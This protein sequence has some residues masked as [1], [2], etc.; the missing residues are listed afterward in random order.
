M[1]RVYFCPFLEHGLWRCEAKWQGG[2]REDGYCDKTDGP[3]VSA[4]NTC[5]WMRG[6][7][8]ILVSQGMAG[9]GIKGGCLNMERLCC[10][11]AIQDERP[12]AKWMRRV[13]G[14]ELETE[15]NEVLRLCIIELSDR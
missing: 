13:G 1:T 9:E 4:S 12:M 3:F 8:A 2:E 5:T 10:P 15:G 7:L 14:K 11:L 6:G